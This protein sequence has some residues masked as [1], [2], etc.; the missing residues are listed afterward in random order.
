MRQLVRRQSVVEIRNSKVQATQGLDKLGR[1]LRNILHLIWWFVFSMIAVSRLWFGGSLYPPLYTLG[2]IVNLPQYKP[3]N[4]LPRLSEQ[5]PSVPTSPTRI[6]VH[7]NILGYGT[8][9]IPYYAQFVPRRIS[10]S[11]GSDS[12]RERKRRKMRNYLL[13]K[14]QCHTRRICEADM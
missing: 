3:R 12:G 9:S 7:Y 14:R 13:I 8:C 4:P 2:D 1:E 10:Y 11:L 5:F 6:R